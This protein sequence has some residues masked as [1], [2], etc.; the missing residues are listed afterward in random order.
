MQLGIITSFFSAIPTALR[1][2]V[3]AIAGKSRT[4]QL[5]LNQNREHS[6]Q[7]LER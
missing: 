3:E 7:G 2:K 6:D 5:L 1:L 4:R